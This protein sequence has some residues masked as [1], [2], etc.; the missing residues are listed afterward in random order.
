MEA[1]VTT[2]VAL[3][4]ALRDGPGYGRELIL[5]VAEA[6]EGMVRLSPARVYAALDAL[7][8]QIAEKHRE[9]G[10]L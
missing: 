8:D 7:A 3:L 2:R 4:Q 5:R 9:A 1:P 10:L 6:S